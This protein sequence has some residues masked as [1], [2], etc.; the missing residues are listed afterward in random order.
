MSREERMARAGDYVLG[1]MDEK[2]RTRAERDME[3]DA[4]F[5]DCV[6][7]LAER[8]HAFDKDVAPAEV[9]GDMWQTVAARIADMPQMTAADIA[10]DRLD[11]TTFQAPDPSRKGILQLKRPYAHQFAGWRGGLI[12]ACLIGALGVGY[13]SGQAM[14]PAPEPVVVVV[15]ADE[16]NAPGAFVEAYGND[17]V[18]IVPLV[19]FEVPQGKTLEVWTLYDRE[20]GPVSLGTFG[21]ST[22]ITLQG[23]DQPMPQP[24]QLYEITLEDAP[25]S[26]VGRPT[27]PILV[28]GLAVRPPR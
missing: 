27:G 15:L 10:R 16:D 3:V 21:R 23:P 17:A 4:E 11:L 26:P 18:R 1:L 24:E 6:I 28:K 8:F 13:L 5:R 25:G 2:E 12:A 19:D 14:G 22:E 9:P 20:V 7:H